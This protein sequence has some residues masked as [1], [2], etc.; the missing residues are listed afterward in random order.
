[1]LTDNL[2]D[3]LKHSYS[4]GFLDFVK[5]EGSKVKAVSEDKSVI[6]RGNL[7]EEIAELSGKKVG[8]SNMAILKGLLD[9]PPFHMPGATS[10]IV[11]SNTRDGEVYPRDIVFKSPYNHTSK[12][13]LMSGQNADKKV[14]VP[15]LG[16]DSFDV[17]F[18]VNKKNLKDMSYFT[19][20]LNSVNKV[21]EVSLTKG[22]VEFHLGD[23]NSC[24]TAIPIA[25]N[26]RGSL[27]KGMYFPLTQVLAI[28]KLAEQDQCSIGIKDNIG[29]T[30]VVT[31]PLGEY[32]YNIQAR[33]KK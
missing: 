13:T 2:K 26:V 5:I 8:M 19:G 30:I 3:I 24:K 18:S 1:M 6:L 27:T 17:E 23:D 28:L 14:M 29:M 10:E 7:N 25:E 31:S 33:K 32:S 21:F 9:F 4:L 22:V 16:Y 12:Y 20:L 15:V 11:N